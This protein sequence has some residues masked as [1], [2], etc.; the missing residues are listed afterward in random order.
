M[1]DLR[2]DSL[3][4]TQLHI[5]GTKGRQEH[6]QAAGAGAAGRSHDGGGH[7]GRDQWVHIQAQ[8]EF[9][10]Q[11]EA[12]GSLDYAAEAGDHGG[13][14]QGDQAVGGRIID[15]IAE[16]VDPLV[17]QGKG[18]QAAQ[19]QGLN[20]DVVGAPGDSVLQHLLHHKDIQHHE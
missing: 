2:I 6:G 18:Q 14:H 20:D 15:R 3:R 17:E 10:D 8:C 5:L 9:L 11:L 19:G 12:M 16:G 1:E 4:L 13:V 7:A